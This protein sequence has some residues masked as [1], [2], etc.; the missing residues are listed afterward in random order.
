MWPVDRELGC[1]DQLLVGVP[2]QRQ[3]PL[4]PVPE[5]EREHADEAFDGGLQPPSF[6]RGQDDLGIAV[7]AEIDAVVGEL[8]A[9]FAVI[10]DLAIVGDDVAAAGR[11][12]RLGRDVI[13]IDDGQ[14]SAGKGY[15]GL[16]VDIMDRT[17]VATA[18]TVASSR[19]P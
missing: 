7:A 11:D 4:L 8:A 3:L 5:R 12:H 15:P 9:Q 14:P 6:D 13:E 10:V 16:A 2:N 19:W 17:A 1:R 18:A